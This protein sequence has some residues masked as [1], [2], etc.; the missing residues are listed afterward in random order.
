VATGSP[1]DAA[2]LV[3]DLATSRPPTLGQGRLI[4]VDGPAGSGKTTLAAAIAERTGAKVVHMDDLM[5]GWDGVSGTGPQLASILE[6]LSAGRPGSYRHFNWHLD[7][8]DRVVYVPVAD[9]LVIEGV[10]SGHPGV[11]HLVTALVWVEAGEE[12]RL[13]RG[14]DR[15]GADMEPQWR[16]FMLEEAGVFSTHRTRER[17]DV[18]VDGTGSLRPVLR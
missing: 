1:P 13:A 9:W 12:L 17:A 16:Q 3:V 11:A 8:F 2:G 4:C 5:D 15:D 6:P 7:R 10:G 14:L 18:V